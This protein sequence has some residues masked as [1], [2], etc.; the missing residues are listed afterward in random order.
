MSNKKV[1]ALQSLGQ[2]LDYES[3]TWLAMNHPR[4]TNALETAVLSGASVE[5]IKRQAWN[6]TQRPEIVVRMVNATRWLTLEDPADWS[7]VVG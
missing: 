3:Y 5:D 6:H 2:I 7:G 4:I 1:E